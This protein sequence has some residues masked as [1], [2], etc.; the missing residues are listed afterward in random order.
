M[1]FI[2]KE[3]P[4]NAL[5]L[6]PWRSNQK[7]VPNECTAWVTFSGHSSR[8]DQFSSVQSRSH[9]RFFATPRTAACQASLSTT[10]SQSL[11]KLMSIESVM[12]STISFCVGPLS[13][14][15]QSFPASES[16]QMSQFFTLSG[17]SIGS[18]AL[19]SVLPMNI[20]D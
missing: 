18:L 19:A 3:R 15:F 12:P 6:T 20:Q 5:S 14:C 9:G 1:I 4:V 8:S 7:E 17:E 10:S 13:S 16:F 11:L 2:Q